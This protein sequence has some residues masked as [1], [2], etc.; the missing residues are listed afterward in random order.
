LLVDFYSAITAWNN[1]P[2]QY[3]LVNV[4]DPVCPGTPGNDSSYDLKNNCSDKQLDATPGK[5]AGW[6]KNYAYSDHF[7]P[8]PYG[9]QLLAET[10]KQA[11]T[12]VGWL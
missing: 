3:A 7:H 6:W 1:D 2:Y 8:T 12:R 5:I 10:V 4:T 9:H 11:L